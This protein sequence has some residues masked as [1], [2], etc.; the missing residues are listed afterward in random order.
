MDIGRG[1]NTTF[2]NNEVSFYS[3]GIGSPGNF[4]SGH[5]GGG[6]GFGLPGL[7][8]NGTGLN[9]VYY[10]WK[11]GTY[12]SNT[13]GYDEVGWEFTYNHSVLPNAKNYN[14]SAWWDKEKSKQKAKDDFHALASARNIGY[15]KQNLG[16]PPDGINPPVSNIWFYSLV[17]TNIKFLPLSTSGRDLINYSF[18]G[19]PISL[20]FSNNAKISL[21]LSKEAGPFGGKVSGS[22]SFYDQKYSSAWEINYPSSQRNWADDIWT[23]TN[24]SINLT[25][26]SYG[27]IDFVNYSKQFIDSYIYYRTHPQAKY[28]F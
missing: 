28:G 27:W 10:D 20:S 17:L 18:S 26:I 15:G 7:Y 11:T 8:G 21:S 22:F 25:Q 2:E 24:P 5:G 23:P 14:F 3:F 6:D 13:N 1:I 16:D 9:G 19:T 12:R 4:Y